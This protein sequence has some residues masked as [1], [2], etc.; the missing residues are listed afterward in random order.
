MPGVRVGVEQADRHRLGLGVDQRGD[1]PLELVAAQRPEDLAIGG[2][3]LVHLEAQL[4][5][6][7][8]LGAR[9]AAQVVKVLARLPAD[10]KQIAKS[11]GR[12]QCDAG[13]APLEDRIRDSGS[14][15]HHR[16]HT[17]ACSVAQRAGGQRLV[18]NLRRLGVAARLADVD[19][20]GYRVVRD[21]VGEGA[22]GVDAHAPAAGH[23]YHIVRR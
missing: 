7:G 16:L 5:G 2:N 15:V 19:G 21:H 20:P 17:L 3:A 23:P 13:S 4:P 12:D 1:Q 8:R 6:N 9:R 10:G 14:A 22:T 11:P 18:E